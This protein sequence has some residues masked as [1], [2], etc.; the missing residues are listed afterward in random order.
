MCFTLMATT[1]RL[2]TIT[3][4]TIQPLGYV[5]TRKKLL[6]KRLK[7]SKK[8]RCLFCT[9]FI[10][11]FLQPTFFYK[12]PFWDKKGRREGHEAQ[13]PIV[14]ADLPEACRHRS[15]RGNPPK[16]KGVTA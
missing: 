13:T 4:T 1:D 7:K 3:A 11:F 16:K 14:G 12:M 5:A 8:T 15:Q 9:N 2:A 6:T 10:Y